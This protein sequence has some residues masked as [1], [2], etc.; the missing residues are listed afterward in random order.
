MELKQ[1]EKV[2]QTVE[3]GDRASG[4]RLMRQVLLAEPNYAP[5]WFWM[6]RLVDDPRRK[7]E[8]LERALALDPG[9]KPA[10]DALE[11]LRAQERQPAPPSAMHEPQKIG[12]YLVERGFVTPRQLEVALMEQHGSQTWGKRVPL[13]DILIRR[14]FLTPQDLARALVIQQ[15]D[16]RRAGGWRPERLG[17][18]LIVGKL[19]SP[20][21][22]AAALAEQVR[23][24]QRGQYVVL[25]ELLVRRGFL[26]LDTL[27]RVLDRQRQDFFGGLDN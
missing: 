14:G 9:L 6:S 26:K 15:R 19:V 12:A 3:H 4:Y 16:R 1:F 21:H 17:E 18:Y 23:L 11:S 24:R 22:L 13:G 20:E 8:C 2:V 27:E 10:R 5:A 25:G 7:R